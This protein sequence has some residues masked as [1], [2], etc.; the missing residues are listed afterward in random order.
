MGKGSSGS[1]TRPVTQQEADLWTAQKENLDS[2]TKIAEEQYNLSEE[3]R[4][5]YEKT[6]REG[7]D[8]EAK[9]ALAKL[10]SQITGN[11]VSPENIE[12]VNI[13]SLLRDTILNSTPEFKVAADIYLKNSNLLTSKYGSDVTGI[14][15]AFADSSKS[16]AA[17]YGKEVEAQTTDYKKILGNI[18]STYGT[19]LTNAT[20][21]YGQ[22][23]QDITSKFGNEISSLQTN[24]DN[25]LSEISSGMGTANADVLARQTGTTMAGISS[26]YQEARKQLESTLARKGLAGSGVEAD[27]LSQ[28]YQQEAMNKA[29]AGVSA[30]NT[31]IQ[32]SD[33]LRQQQAQLATQ[34]YS[35]GASTIQQQLVAQ[36]QAAQGIYG[37]NASL[38]SNIYQAGTG[39]AGNIYQA[40]NTSAGQ[41]YQ[42]G[43]AGATTGYQANL[44]A[45]QNIYGVTSA[46]D[47]QNYNLSNAATLQ[48]I[49]G[50]TQVAQAGQGVYAQS[51]N[52]LQGASSSAASAASTAGSSATGLANVNANY[53]TQMQQAN[54]QSSAGIGSLVGTMAMAGATAYA[55]DSRLKTNIQLVDNI[56]G[57]NIYT[58]DWKEQDYGYNKG[59]IAQEILVSVP[60]AVTMMDN[61]YYAVNYNM[62]G[63]DYLVKGE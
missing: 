6:F 21:S 7:T 27:V 33:A 8:T 30:Y 5:Y 26:G 55:S 22:T 9:T 23:T 59:V 62:L 36:Q 20:A 17:N 53:A 37:A 18:E 63:L 25:K 42:A 16:Y 57:H 43:I 2:L 46:S 1:S 58:W 39:N 61:G 50:L 40:S 60:E 52:Y 31:A 38:A 48:G 56:N 29:S 41:Q 3:D 47:L 10:Q 54:A 44:G 12:S 45:T 34:Q 35:T 4:A 11:T 13:D 24:L 15:K 51:A 19:K 32:Q 49:A 28:N 14:S